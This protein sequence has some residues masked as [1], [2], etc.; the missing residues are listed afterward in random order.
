MQVSHIHYQWIPASHISL[1]F[2]DGFLQLPRAV[3][4]IGRGNDVSV[5]VVLTWSCKQA[6]VFYFCRHKWAEESTR[7]LP[8][9]PV[10]GRKMSEIALSHSHAGF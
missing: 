10:D 2:W 9:S 5:D 4:A 6:E 8:L 7:A 1:D 3:F